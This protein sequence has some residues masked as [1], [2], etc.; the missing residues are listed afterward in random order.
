MGSATA[1]IM[2]IID[3]LCALICNFLIVNDK[4]QQIA[5][6]F[7][8][9]KITEIQH[10]KDDINLSETIHVE[11]DEDEHTIPAPTQSTETTTQSQKLNPSFATTAPF[12]FLF[13]F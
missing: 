9:H 4:S 5:S 2:V 6:T 12:R 8:H 10:I 1:I 13:Y 7:M 11:N 3:C